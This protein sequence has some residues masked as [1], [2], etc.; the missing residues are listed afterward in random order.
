[1][2]IPRRRHTMEEYFALERVG[3]ARYEYWNG[4]ILCMSGG[5]LQHARIGGNIFLSLGTRLRAGGCQP[6][7][8]EISIKTPQLPPYRYPDVSVVCGEPIIEKI[9]GFD[10]LVNPIV[11]IEVLSPGTASLDRN[12]KRAAYQAIPSVR[13][14]LLISQEAPMVTQYL[15]QADEEWERRDLGGLTAIV[16]LPSLSCRLPLGEVYEGVPFL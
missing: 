12:Q 4:D 6:F 1:M 13:E 9:E 2:D 5:S 8:G 7:T 11:V 14:V 16:E 15:R 3:D 10:V